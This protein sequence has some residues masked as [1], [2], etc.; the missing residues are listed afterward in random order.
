MGHG[1]C[2]LKQRPLE[3]ETGC[4]FSIPL[5]RIPVSPPIGRAKKCAARRGKSHRGAQERTRGNCSQ[6][7]WRE[8]GS[9]QP[10]IP[11]LN[12]LLH[13]S[14]CRAGGD[15]NCHFAA[16]DSKVGQCRALR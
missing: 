10:C 4:W 9:C 15:A 3:W 11:L 2:F 6:L 8:Q 7:M 1:T 12:N 14:W 5:E 16:S 13:G